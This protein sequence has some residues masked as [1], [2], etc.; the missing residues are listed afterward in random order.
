MAIN[1]KKKGSKAERALCKWWETW[2]GLEFNRVP[3]SGGLRWQ[4]TDNISGDIICTSERES[5]RFP[6]S[7]ES[8]AYNDIRFE[9][10]VIGN[11]KSKVREFWDQSK[12][13]ALRSNKYPILFMRYNGMKANTWMVMIRQQE[14]NLLNIDFSLLDY[15]I[16]KI[17]S[18]EDELVIINSNDLLKT[19]YKEFI[20]LI[21]IKRNGEKRKK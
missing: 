13:D 5:R 9:H 16:I 3:A 19:N 17:S 2:S 11:K 15:P 20:K 6:F 1:R 10:Y 12:S 18:K 4:K 21:K 14:Y 8:K 7:V